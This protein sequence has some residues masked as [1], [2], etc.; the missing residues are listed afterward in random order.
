MRFVATWGDA[1]LLAISALTP[2]I[3][4]FEIAPAQPVGHVAPGAHIQVQVL[5]GDQP[6]T[7][8][9][10]VLDAAPDGRLRI[11]VKLLPESRGGS[12]YMWSLK[13]GG[14]LRIS[15]PLNHFEL[16][17]TCPEYLLLAGGIGITP[18]H[19]MAI[20]LQQRGC[21]VR[22]LYAARTRQELALADDLRARLGDRLEVFASNEGQR[23]PLAEALAAV[24][25]GG[26]VYL[27]GPVPMLEAARRAWSSLGRP[28]S[29]LRF[30]TFGGSGLLPTRAFTVKIPRL[31]LEVD[32][33][34]EQ[35]LLSRLQAAGADIL[36]DCLRGECGLCA[37]DIVAT[38]GGTV[39][40]RDVFFSDHEKAE[41][42]KICA[43]VSRMSGGCL[44]LDTADRP[45]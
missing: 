18:I 41:G 43:C 23:L 10:S 25:H 8:C 39:D 37:L 7:R 38:E 28:A 24:G 42:R 17:Y 40:H 2:T 9:Y 36:Y 5:I 29:L 1:C 30:E 11:A 26:A 13:P 33:P 6:D 20:A 32:V 35:T 44:T 21:A 31:G 16:S 45:H 34:A 4:Q 12:A 27:C 19:A 14:A 22:V 15:A 3:R